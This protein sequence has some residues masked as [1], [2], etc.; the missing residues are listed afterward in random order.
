MI[1]NKNNKG[2]TIE[3]FPQEG[4]GDEAQDTKHLK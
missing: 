3:S 4:E 1:R 2:P